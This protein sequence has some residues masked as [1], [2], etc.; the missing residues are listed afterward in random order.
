M[1]DTES[2]CKMQQMQFKQYE[3]SGINENIKDKNDVNCV[4]NASF[5]K[6][7]DLKGPENK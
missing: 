5:N 2:V 6:K 3:N 7:T 1:L 4:A